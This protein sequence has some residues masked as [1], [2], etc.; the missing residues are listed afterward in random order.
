MV[1]L[2]RNK[3]SGHRCFRRVH[4]SDAIVLEFRLA[5]ALAGTTALLAAGVLDIPHLIG[6]ARMDL[7]LFLVAM[8]IVIGFLEERR[9]FEVVVE[10]GERFNAGLVSGVNGLACLRPAPKSS[11]DE[12]SRICPL[13]GG[14]LPRER[15]P[16]LQWSPRSAGR[17]PVPSGLA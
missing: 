2:E 5:L 12:G 6:F 14:A 15:A 4:L 3:G 8:M 1:G 17:S 13:L 10:R 11:E 9:F 7:I 16:G